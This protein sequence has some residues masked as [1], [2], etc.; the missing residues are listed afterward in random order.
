MPKEIAIKSSFA[1]FASLRGLFS[2]PEVETQRCIGQMR[3]I[4]LRTWSNNRALVVVVILIADIPIKSVV[5]LD[6]Q[7]GFRRLKTHRVRGD[8]R[9][10]V[11]RR[12]RQSIPLTVVL[13]D[14]ISGE[15]SHAR[16]DTG[17]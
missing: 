10:W 14:P 2:P 3:M 15:Q 5:Q 16:R 9:A 17:D 1:P 4:V 13:V 8:Q 6:N 12:I 7:P 11:P